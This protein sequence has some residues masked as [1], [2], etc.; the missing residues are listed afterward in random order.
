M[1]ACGFIVGSL[2]VLAGAMNIGFFSDNPVNL[3]VGTIAIVTGYICLFVA[4]SAS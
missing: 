2:A 3:I 1:K 4:A